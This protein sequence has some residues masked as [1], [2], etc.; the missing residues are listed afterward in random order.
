MGK[1]IVFNGVAVTTPI[2]TV[3]FVVP[4]VTGQDYVNQYS[5]LATA[6]TAPQKASLSTFIDTL[7]ANSLWDKV[8]NCFPMLGGLN[9]YKFDCKDLRNQKTWSLPV[10]YT[11]WDAVRNAPYVVPQYDVAPTNT[12]QGV[13]VPLSGVNNS[14]FCL[15]YSNKIRSSGESHLSQMR[16]SDNTVGSQLSNKS[17]G[18][19]YPRWNTSPGAINI[20]GYS[21]LNS[22]TFVLNYLNGVGSGQLKPASEPVFNLGVASAITKTISSVQLSLSFDVVATSLSSSAFYGNANMFVVCNTGLTDTEIG[23][24]ANAIHT[25]NESCGR[26]IVW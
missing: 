6:V 9:G 4:L 19:I 12:A 26:N 7:I 5:L 18:A 17:G 8:S 21:P 16:F 24:I 25:F 23:I 1:A 20:N 3:N 15:L 11:T 14:N 13:A 22:N 2:Q 10:P